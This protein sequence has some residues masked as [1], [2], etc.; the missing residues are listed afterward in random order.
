MAEKRKKLISVVV[1]VFNE[2]GNVERLYERIEQVM[3]PLSGS[4]D[5]EL[6]FTDNHSIDETFAKLQMLA[7]RDRRV[8]IFRFSRNFGFQKSIYTGYIKARG[9]A[10]IQIDCDL[11]D[12]PELIPEFIKL[13][14]EGYQ[15]VYGVRRSR[16]ESWWINGLRKIFY[17]FIDIL[18][19]DHLPYDAGDFRLV[20][21]RVLDELKKVEDSQPYLRGAIST[22]GFDQIGIPYDRAERMTGESKFSMSDLLGLAIDGILN[23][24]VIPLRIATFTGLIVS[25]LT[26]LGIIVYLAGRAFFGRD[27]PAG[28]ATTTVLILL[29]LSLNALF[30][31]IIGEYLGRIYKQIKKR[32][33]T[34]TEKEIDPSDAVR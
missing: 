24:S 22:M 1:P 29:T 32:P 23:H 12:P 28:F 16:R 13:W 18:S 27:W 9:D 31:G 14:E 8:R 15:V 34:I 20:D 2:E 21:R 6:I 7:S 17:R 11:Q 25:V 3:S 4:Y 10:A 5:Y 30:L 26:F 19:E 33:L